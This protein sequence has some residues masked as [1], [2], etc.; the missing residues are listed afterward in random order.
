MKKKKMGIVI[1]VSISLLL[2]II[3][4]TITR[5]NKDKD[6]INE[7]VNK[8][9]PQGTAVVIIKNGAITDV[10]N[11]GYANVEKKVP[12]TDE[13]QFKI[14]SISKTVT[15]YAVMK[16]V[17]EG[18]LNLDTPI[19]TYLTRWQLPNTQFDKNKVTLRTLMSHTSGITG[20]DECGYGELLPTIDES[21]KD[22]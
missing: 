18:K 1:V 7:L 11:Y 6:Y 15:S 17:D 3:A 16:L 10:R 9:N 5:L 19:N 2:S 8:Y 12:V 22:R 13:T 21:L 20:S 4:L 14:A